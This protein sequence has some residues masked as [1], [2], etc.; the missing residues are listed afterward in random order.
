[1]SCAQ[2]VAARELA[3]QEAMQRQRDLG[4]ARILDHVAPAPGPYLVV[5]HGFED[6]QVLPSAVLALPLRLSK[7]PRTCGK[8]ASFA[9]LTL[10]SCWM[11]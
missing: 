4:A 5:P 2:A 8:C 3:Q 10:S 11:A 1:M 6:R 9:T 7:R